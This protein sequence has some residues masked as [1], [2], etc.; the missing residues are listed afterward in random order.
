M[1]RPSSPAVGATVESAGLRHL[2]GVYLTS[3]RREGRVIHA[4]GSEFVIAAGDV[5]YFSGVPDGI[6]ELAAKHKLVP[7]S[8][9]LETIDTSDVPNLSAAFGT[10]HISGMC[11]IWSSRDG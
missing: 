10:D 6:E 2:E 9:A 8:D 3:A 11:C 7:Y 5:L 1:V 4:V